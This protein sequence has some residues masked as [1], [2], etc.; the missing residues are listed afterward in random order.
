MVAGEA[1]ASE[2]HAARELAYFLEQITGAWFA[3]VPRS[4]GGGCRLL[5]GEQAGRAADPDFSIEGLGAEGII[6]RTAG[7]DLIL[8][9]GHPRGTL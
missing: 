9:G 2:Q 8:A 6:M 3:I 5:V 1:S 7:D 4:A